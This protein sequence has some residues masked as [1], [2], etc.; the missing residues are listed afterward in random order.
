MAL[1]IINICRYLVPFLEIGMIIINVIPTFLKL[2][3]L[4]RFILLEKYDNISENVMLK[5]FEVR[6]KYL[7]LCAQAYVHAQTHTPVL[8]GTFQASHRFYGNF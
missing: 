4:S 3:I 7:L 1:P 8:N 6:H 5:K 2:I